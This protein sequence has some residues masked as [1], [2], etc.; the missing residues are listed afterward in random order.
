MGPVIHGPSLSKK[1]LDT[2]M[3]RKQHP[4]T[5]REEAVAA[6]IATGTYAGASRVTGISQ[7][8]IRVWHKNQPTWWDKAAERIREQN[9]ERHRANLTKIMD[10]CSEEIM[11]RLE[12]GD[13]H[14]NSKGEK[15]RVKVKAQ[16]IAVIL[17]ITS[18]KRSLSLGLPTSISGKQNSDTDMLKKLKHLSARGKATEKA[19]VV[20][21]RPNGTERND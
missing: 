1:D 9:E 17:G 14:I 12:H 6:W 20:E 16:A 4:D 3:N 5:A 18:E 19:D 21:L 8:T 7:A 15:H 2:T 10:K 13:E 11:E